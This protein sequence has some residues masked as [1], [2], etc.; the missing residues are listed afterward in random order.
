MVINTEMPLDRI[1]KEISTAVSGRLDIFGCN[2]QN[3]LIIENKINSK[4][5]GQQTEKYYSFF[6]LPIFKNVN[7][8]FV[9]LTVNKNDQP[10]NENFVCISYQELYDEV[11]SKCMANEELEEESR[12]LLENYIRNL[13]APSGSEKIKFSDDYKSPMIYRE[14]KKC[15]NLCQRYAE[16]FEYLR[17]KNGDLDFFKQYGNLI[18][19]ILESAGEEKI[20]NASRIN[21]ME[22]ALRLCE[23]KIIKPDDVSSEFCKKMYSRD[24]NGGAY[25]I[26]QLVRRNGRYYFMIGYEAEREYHWTE[27]VEPLRDEMGE[28]MLFSSASEALD[29]AIYDYKIKIVRDDK[30]VFGHNAAPSEL[31]NRIGKSLPEIY[32]EKCM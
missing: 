31:R 30:F 13:A 29:M 14:A 16:D 25:F 28:P 20:K 24:K 32:T 11:L 21:F 18:N 12:F 2:E 9:Y 19:L 6:N 10:A 22:Q 23:Q 4:E 27:E 26:L 7:K 5:N 15:S 3:I 1:Q 17:E 8:M